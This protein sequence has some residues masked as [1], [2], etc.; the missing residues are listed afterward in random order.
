[1]ISHKIDFIGDTRYHLNMDIEKPDQVNKKELKE[2]TELDK[3]YNEK[4]RVIT[5]EAARLKLFMGHELGME[6]EQKINEI[7]LEKVR[8]ILEHTGTFS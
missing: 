3:E 4:L 8:D 2:A 5:E 6:D 7:I 1:M